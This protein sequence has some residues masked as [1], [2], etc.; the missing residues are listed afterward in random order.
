MKRFFLIL[1]SGIITV[2]S[3]SGSMKEDRNNFTRSVSLSSGNLTLMAGETFDLS[4]SFEGP[5][6][7]GFG[8][9]WTSDNQSAVVLEPAEK[10]SEVKLVAVGEGTSTVSFA[11][12]DAAYSYLSASVEVTVVKNE[13]E[14]MQI[15][16]IGN[17]FSE[18][19]VEQNLYELFSAA[20][21]N[22]IIG[23]MYI[24]G[25]TLERHWSNIQ[26][27]TAS[28]AF[29]EVVGGIKTNTAGKAL[30][31]V[32]TSREWDVIS[33]QQQSGSSGKF[34]T[35]EPYLTNI[36]KYVKEK[37]PSARLVF[38]QTW[39]Y[40]Q[41]STHSEFGKYDRDQMTMY[42]AIVA[43]SKKVDDEYADIDLIIPSGTA[44]QNARTSYMGDN[45]C[46]DGYHM[47]REHGRYL[48][49]CTWFEA[50][51]GADVTG[52]AY[53]PLE[54]ASLTAL[55]RNAA[56]LAVQCPYSITDMVDFKEKPNVEE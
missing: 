19:A 4:A 33:L 9:C 50:L 37:C 3:C 55:C 26:N 52:N 45:F 49:A 23:N 5:G 31:E 46:R 8:Y 18:D 22:V 36:I 24:G 21:R 53:T 54:D 6:T 1:L 11:C 47:N 16:A 30:E 38:H 28:Y 14:V 39:A 56:H 48:V 41:N 12:T 27:N 17:S 29:R 7:A 42:E 25:C 35:Y 43:A 32:L 13:N 44:V 40:A 51:T 20:G 15:L 34:E 2:V 10:F